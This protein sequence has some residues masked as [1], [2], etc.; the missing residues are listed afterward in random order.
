MSATLIP[1]HLSNKHYPG[2]A[3]TG[4]AESIIAILPPAPI[5][6]PLLVELWE[7]DKYFVSIHSD[8]GS[9]HLINGNTL[10]VIGCTV[11]TKDGKRVR[12]LDYGGNYTLEEIRE[13]VSGLDVIEL[14]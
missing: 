7:T 10:G 11:I 4:K 14:S 8:L 1:M 2:S 13:Y 6:C 12:A 9:I 5:L 3:L